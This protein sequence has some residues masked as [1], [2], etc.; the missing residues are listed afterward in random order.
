M[1]LF[2][3]SRSSLHRLFLLQDS[4][5]LTPRRSDWHR[6]T[7]IC[8][9]MSRFPF[10]NDVGG[11]FA[12]VHTLKRRQMMGIGHQLFKQLLPQAE[13]IITFSIEEM[14]HAI[15]RVFVLANNLFLVHLLFLLILEFLNECLDI[16]AEAVSDDCFVKDTVDF[17]DH[18]LYGSKRIIVRYRHPLA[19][20]GK[21]DS[22][23]TFSPSR[24]PIFNKLNTLGVEIN[25]PIFSLDYYLH[26]Y[27]S[28]PPETSGSFPRVDFFSPHDL[29]IPRCILGHLLNVFHLGPFEPCPQGVFDDIAQT[30]AVHH[31]RSEIHLHD[32]NGLYLGMLV[33]LRIRRHSSGCFLV[34]GLGNLFCQF[35]QIIFI[36]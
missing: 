2:R 19:G 27:S 11:Y 36:R 7:I 14:I 29:Y 6:L 28:F 4:I 18:G 24:G 8:I 22:G 25:R 5:R 15:K 21:D 31:L 9:R 20:K 32:F 17:I 13:F 12:L 33:V 26:D 35:I 10:F 1:H 23:N 34:H 16:K 30:E 3:S